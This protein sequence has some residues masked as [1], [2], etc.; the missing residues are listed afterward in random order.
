[1]AFLSCQG[2]TL[3]IAD[4]TSINDFMTLHGWVCKCFQGS[5]Y[6]RL[7]LFSVTSLQNLNSDFKGYSQTCSLDFHTLI[8]LRNH[9]PSSSVLKEGSEFW[10]HQA[11]SNRSLQINKVVVRARSGQKTYR[12]RASKGQKAHVINRK[13]SPW[14][15]A[16]QYPTP[17]M[18]IVAK[19]VE[20][21]S[22]Y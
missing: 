9:S 20:E 2:C 14:R 13:I 3:P 21:R 7:K 8:R 12:G 10:N 16:P 15:V 5:F 22:P 6:Q 19:E 1:M 17:I 11:K 4:S 18:R